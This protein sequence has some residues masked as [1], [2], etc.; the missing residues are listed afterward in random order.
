M[1]ARLIAAE[2]RQAVEHAAWQEAD[3]AYLLHR[4]VKHGGQ[5]A[6]RDKHNARPRTR[7]VWCVARRVGKT[8]GL[9]V[10][11]FETC[12]ATPNA[13]VPYAAM[14]FVSLKQFIFPIARVLIDH[15][16]E[17]LRP[18]L[19][20]NEVRFHNGSV[21]VF[22]GCETQDMADRLRGPAAHRVIVDE[23]GFIPVLAYVV[24]S[25][26]QWQLAT[27]RGDMIIAS[28]PP[29]TAAHSFAEFAAEAEAAGDYVHADV[30][31]APHLTEED[32]ADQCVK[33]GGPTSTAWKREGLAQFVTD[34]ARSL[35]PEF[36]EMEHVVV[37]E[38]A[39]GPHVDRYVVGDGG[40]ND[41]FVVAYIEWDFVHNVFFVFD[42]SVFS[43]KA[44]SEV[45]HAVNAKER[46]WWKG[47]EIRGRYIDAQPITR[48]DM[49]RIMLPNELGEADPARES[50]W[51]AARND[52]KM[53]AVNRLR[54]ATQYG[55]YRI[56]PRCKTIIAHMRHGI[57]NE[58]RTDFARPKKLLEGNQIA[59]GHFDGVAVCMYAER[60]VDRTHNPTPALMIDPATQWLSPTAHDLLL[61]AQARTVKKWAGALTRKRT[62]A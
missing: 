6:W 24:T 50:R 38:H 40:F 7:S 46:H 48:A 28:S 8:H 13:R 45:Q 47:A 3:L 1:T 12:L 37:S 21:I 42:E 51:R 54:V 17:A 4:G 26:L 49:T 33:A 43:R 62:R 5:R 35:V 36:T 30:Y 2:E 32:V 61:P 20:G 18:A 52:E 53:A 39:C 55:R 27:T 22:Q 15:A 29:E 59:P 11:A 58:K 57:W 19:V 34:P 31:E 25:V 16:P 60:H 41:L 56:H 44:S 10:M 23:A 14:S 9:L